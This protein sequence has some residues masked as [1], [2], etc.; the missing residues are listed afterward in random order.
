MK[1][2][3]NF[4]RVVLGGVLAIAVNSAA[5]ARADYAFAFAE[6]TISNVVV[7][8]TGGATFVNTTPTTFGTSDSASLRGFPGVANQDQLDAPEAYTGTPP[9]AP[10]NLFTKWA[11]FAAGSPLPAGQQ[12]T[13]PGPFSRGDVLI[14]F[15]PAVV[16]PTASNVAETY[17]TLGSGAA[18]GAFSAQLTFQVSAN[19]NISTSYNFANDIYASVGGNAIA[20]ASFKFDVSVKDNLGNIV[21]DFA[22]NQTNV[23]DSA[24]VNTPEKVTAGAVASPG[25]ALV[26]G[27]TYTLTFSGAETTFVNVNVVPEPSSLLM[28]SMAIGLVG[29]VCGWRT[30]KARQQA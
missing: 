11:T 16:T 22:P 23:S 14:Q 29:G 5:T 8:L 1:R 10:E 3:S 30:R 25:A 26:A 15:P 24:P 2:F 28:G 17:S 13:G 20:Q 18:T 27:T 7:A 6:Q 19:T 4:W 9:P 12:P 21:L